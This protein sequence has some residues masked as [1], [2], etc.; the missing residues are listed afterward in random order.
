MEIIAVA[1]LG[2]IIG[3]LP[4]GYLIGRAK[5]IDIFRH[6]S[7][8]IGAT[9]VWR[10]FGPALG[11]LAFAGDM[12]KGVLSV[13]IG[14][15]YGEWPAVA[16]AACALLGHSWSVFLGFKG[17]KIVATALGVF[18]M[19]TWKAAL[20]SFGIWGLVLFLTRYVSLSSIIAAAS[21]PVTIAF[22][23]YHWSYVL[24]GALAAAVAVYKH[25][26]NIKRLLNCT[27]QRMGR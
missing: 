23:G 16:A 26:G 14:S 6:G 19:L 10:T 2:Y 12:G 9:N 8:N 27:E 11:L 5:G 17:G 1:L 18:I 25:R 7:G 3:S 22:F 4:T 21:L 20:V 13:Y 15:L 24:F